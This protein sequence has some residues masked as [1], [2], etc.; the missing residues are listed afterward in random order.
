MADARTRTPVLTARAAGLVG[1]AT[2]G[3]VAEAARER[4]IRCGSRLHSRKEASLQRVW[5]WLTVGLMCYIPANTLP[6]LVTSTLGRSS[7]STIGG[8]VIELIEHHAYGV[9][10]IVAVASI[11]IPVSKFLIIAY[12]ALSIRHPVA[13]SLHGRTRLYEIVEFVGRWSMIDVFVVAILTA[14]VQLGFVASINPGIA[15]VFFALSV[16][17]T[18]LSA[19]AM[20]P[21]L[22]WDTEERDHPAY[23]PA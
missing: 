21:R 6:M 8:G 5:A 7:A 3:K 18:M 23:E 12:L 2:C 1:C 4:C 22:I 16:A 10:A 9:A 17:F 19:Q 14:L 11:V 13:M 20:D 15:A